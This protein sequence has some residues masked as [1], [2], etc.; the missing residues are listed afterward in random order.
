MAS[1]NAL[2]NKKDD[3]LRKEFEKWAVLTYTS[4]RA[5]INDKKGADGGIDGIAFFK[6]GKSDNAKIIFQVKSGGVKRGDIASLRGDMEKAGAALA[7]LLT[8]EEPTKPMISDAKDAGVFNHIEM[9]RSY[10]RI[11]IVTIKEVVEEGKRLEI[12]M[13]LE[14]LKAAQ[15]ADNAEQLELL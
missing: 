2:A 6:T 13:S 10:D 8:L 11:S 1:A 7:C 4:N 5:I 14:V 15:R 3:R 9:G 12:P